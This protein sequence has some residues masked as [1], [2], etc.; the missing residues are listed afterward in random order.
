MALMHELDASVQTRDLSEESKGLPWGENI[1]DYEPAPDTKWRFGLPNYA[2]VNKTYFQHRSRVHAKGSLEDVVSKIVKNWE[3]E[4]HHI[5]D[6]HQW[7]TMDI[8][9]FKGALNGGCPVSAQLMCDIGPYNML[10]GEAAQYSAKGNTFESAYTIFSNVFTE[11]FAWEVLEV[12]SGPP[13]VTIK[14]RHFGPF[15]GHFI[16]KNGRKYVGNGE[17][18]NVIGLTIAKVNESLVI[19]SLDIYYS[20]EDMLKPLT[21]MVKL[22]EGEVAVGQDEADGKV[23]RGGACCSSAKGSAEAKPSGCGV[24]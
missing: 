15:T 23:A 7:K 2:R 10:I 17:L 1:R 21:T 8:Q 16:D 12:L 19:E 5:A 3:V 9:K 24:M 11:G 6:I 22:G 13:T 20:P 18:V 14:W 4:S